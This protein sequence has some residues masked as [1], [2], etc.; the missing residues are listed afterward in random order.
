MN[1]SNVTII[2]IDPEQQKCES[3]K[4]EMCEIEIGFISFNLIKMR[5]VSFF[6]RVFLLS[7]DFFYVIQT[8]GKTGDQIELMRVIL[9]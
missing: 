3:V 8:K 6:F 7:N 4:L 5:L 9:Q 2:F 1:Q